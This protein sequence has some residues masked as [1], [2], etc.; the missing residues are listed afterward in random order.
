MG[1]LDICSSSIRADRSV[2]EELPIEQHVNVT[3]ITTLKVT[4]KELNIRWKN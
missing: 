1:T 3:T 4:L 2:T